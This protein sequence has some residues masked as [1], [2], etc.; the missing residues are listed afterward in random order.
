MLSTSPSPHRAAAAI[1]LIVASIA[2]LTACLAPA[3]RQPRTLPQDPRVQVQVVI[4]TPPPPM[5][6]RGTES[7]IGC[8]DGQREGFVDVATY[9]N[10]A[11]C[12]GG[13]S[14]PGIMAGHAQVA[15][16]CPGLAIADTTRPACDRGGGD[17]GNT[18]RGEGCNV[19][20]LCAAG[21][22]VCTT[23]GEI[24]LH[25]RNGCNG[26]TRDG[27]PP[28]FFASRQSSTGCAVCAVGVRTEADCNSRSCAASCL[29]TES[30]SNDVFG[31]GNFGVPVTGCGPIDRF[32]NN[33]CASLEGS[34]WSCNAAT[35]ADDTGLCEAYTVIK[36]GPSHGGV[37]CC[38]DD[39]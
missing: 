17:D 12:S 21:W 26:A 28:L 11:G 20:D 15:P 36:S 29:Q 35:A 7:Q 5:P 38:R 19:S 23:A 24:A 18:P 8:A 22:H 27:D 4:A 14:V 3:N 13:W 39:G 25:A 9:P 32:S 2:S 37:L 10:I 31:C 30:I 6:G 34:P 1:A 33:L 16:A